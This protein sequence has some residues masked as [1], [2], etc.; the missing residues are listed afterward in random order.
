MS[1][2]ATILQIQEGEW[3][4]AWARA[5]I[6][7]RLPVIGAVSVRHR[8]VGLIWNQ[9][10]ETFVREEADLFPFGACDVVTACVE[11]A[12]QHNVLER[13][14]KVVQQGWLLFSLN[15][16]RYFYLKMYIHIGV[17]ATA[18]INHHIIQSITFHQCKIW[19]GVLGDQNKVLHRCKNSS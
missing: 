3:S 19:R 17:P 4:R 9:P 14:E 1:V 2:V 7:V 8:G 6:C 12:Q 10:V 13:E 11:V 15:S 18:D 5:A 16:T